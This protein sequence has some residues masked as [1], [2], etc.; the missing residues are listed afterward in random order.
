MPG[1]SNVRKSEFWKEREVKAEAGKGDRQR[2]KTSSFDENFDDAFSGKEEQLDP[3]ESPL[4]PLGAF[5]RDKITRGG[6]SGPR[7]LLDPAELLEEIDRI[8]S[9][10]NNG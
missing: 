7:Y 9:E 8:E 10:E 4:G 2:P 6:I 3:V 1:H 5:A